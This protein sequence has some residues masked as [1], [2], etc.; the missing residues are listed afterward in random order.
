MTAEPRVRAAHEARFGIPHGPCAA[1]GA[2][3]QRLAVNVLTRPGADA[4]LAGRHDLGLGS[5]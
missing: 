1:F 5:G 2:R 3:G 4:G